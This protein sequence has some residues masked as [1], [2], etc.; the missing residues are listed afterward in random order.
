VP[1]GPETWR[2]ARRLARALEGRVVRD[3]WLAWE[4]LAPHAAAFRGEPV[5]RVHARGKATLVVSGCGLVLVSH[6]NLYGRW[7][8]CAAG[9]RPETRRQLRVVLENDRR[10]ALLYSASDVRVLAADELDGHPYLRRLGP[11]ALAPETDAGEVR[12]RMEDARFSGRALA[13]LLLDQGFVAGLGNYLRSEILFEAGVHPDDRPRDLPPMLAEDLAA[14]I[15]AVPR[16]ALDGGG[17]TVRPE[18]I[19]DRTDP[20]RRRGG[21]PRAPRHHVFGRAGR[22]CPRCGA[23]IQRRDAAGRRVYLCPRCQPSRRP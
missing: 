17:R 4:E 7:R 5:V 1:E 9:E 6:N 14:A 15:L 16:R 20:P 2:D 18:L 22:P 23:R 12:A 13:G 21:T 19:G 10:A 3:A 11:D 8:V